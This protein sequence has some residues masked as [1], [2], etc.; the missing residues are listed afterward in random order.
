MDRCVRMVDVGRRKFLSGAGFAAAGAAV[1]QLSPQEAKAAPPAARVDYPSNR[2]AN[3]SDLKVNE[4]LRYRY[5]DGDAPG[6]LIK[7]GKRVATGVGP[8]GDIVGFT[9]MCPHK[10]FPTRLQQD[11]P[12]AELSRPLFALRC[13]SGRPA[14]LGPRDSKPPAVRA[15]RRR[16]RRHLR[17][18]CRRASV[19]PT[20][21]RSV[22]EATMAFKRHIDRLPIVPKDAKEFN[23]VC[24]YCIV[25][26][27]YKAYTWPDQQAGRH[28]ARPEQIRRRSRPTAAGRNRRL[29]CAVDV[30]HRP[31]ERRG[32]AHR[33]QAGPGLRGE[34][35]SR[36]GA[37]RSDGGNE[38]LA[39]AQHRNCSA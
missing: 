13:R 39:H 19:R 38:L 32:R 5:P 2:L 7:L 36:L 15:A 28:R 17:R 25:G 3:I 10:G 20:V 12:D 14:N 23:V 27:G 6:V 26:C 37:R 21:Q 29:V 4:P 31:A 30:Q 11:R 22:R 9:T 16:Q 34:F 24:H 8:D 18:R 1:A 35:R 33:H